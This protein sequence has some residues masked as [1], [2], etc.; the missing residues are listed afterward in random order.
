[1]RD[2][3]MQAISDLNAELEARGFG[4]GSE[5]IDGLGEWWITTWRNHGVEVT[6]NIDTGDIK[7][8]DWGDDDTY[9]HGY[10]WQVAFER[11]VPNPVIL[12]VIDTALKR[13]EKRKR[14]AMQP[15]MRA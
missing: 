5:D 12:A 1:M 15:R 4:R 13:A 14:E 9:T 7:V 2:D 8:S 6:F 10:L 3:W 11:D